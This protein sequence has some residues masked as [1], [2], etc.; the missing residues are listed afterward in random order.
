M[1]RQNQT[2]FVATWV[3][4]FGILIQIIFICR[5]FFRLISMTITL[6][7]ALFLFQEAFEWIGSTFIW[8]SGSGKGRWNGMVGWSVLALL[9]I[10]LYWRRF[11]V[12][13]V[14]I[15]VIPPLLGWA[16]LLQV[17][18]SGLAFASSWGS[19]DGRLLAFFWKLELITLIE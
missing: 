13:A 17:A 8:C 12:E 4:A 10:W 18:L 11:L 7:L 1:Y 5:S 15:F 2:L 3:L 14:L 6:K 9:G 19:G 16:A